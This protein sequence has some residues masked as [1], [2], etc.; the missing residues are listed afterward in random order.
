[1]NNIIIT[2]D[3]NLTCVK[4]TQLNKKYYCSGKLK[5]GKAALKSSN[6]P[7]SIV[8]IIEHMLHMQ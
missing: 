8:F 5:R 1:M 3:N 7:L 2:R 6:K 4:D